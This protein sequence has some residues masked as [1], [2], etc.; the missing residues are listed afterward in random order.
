MRIGVRAHD[1]GKLPAD[2]LTK[3]IAAKGLA[4]VQLNVG[5]AVAGFDMKPGC[6]SPGLADFVG[7]AFDRAG[8]RIAVLSCYVNPIHPD[9]AVRAGN[10]SQFKE[11][12]RYARDFRSSIVALESGSLNA[13][14]SPHPDNHTDRAFKQT[15]AG[16]TELVREAEKFGVIVGIE[17]VTSHVLGTPELMRRALDA[18]ASQNLQVIYDPVNLITAE[19]YKNQRGV[20]EKVFEL[21][22]DRLAVI[23]AK[24][25]VAEG[26]GIKPVHCG[27]GV[28]D[29]P[30]L[31]GLLKQRKP[32]IDILLEGVPE[33]TVDECMAFLNRAAG[34]NH[35]QGK[36]YG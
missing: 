34:E 7:R 4:S 32:Y 18:V 11:I 22:G 33:E 13:D 19:N 16:L 2:E 29:F 3:R 36:N 21:Y 9:P 14:Y 17:G 23:H 10:L 12:V 25:F 27:R 24:D 30:F 6:L 31:L 35:G 26:N 20:M 5:A 15:V 8:V 1:F 28:L